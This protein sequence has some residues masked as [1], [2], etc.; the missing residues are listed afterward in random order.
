MITSIAAKVTTAFI[1][2]SWI[3]C[4]GSWT[5]NLRRDTESFINMFE[6]ENPFRALSSSSSAAV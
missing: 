3:A 4:E 1:V 2:A 5:F 6:C